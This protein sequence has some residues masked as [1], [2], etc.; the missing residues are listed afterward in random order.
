MKIL[1]AILALIVIAA[2]AV[3]S[4]RGQFP[5]SPPI[6]QQ[7]S[8]P[9]TE[10]FEPPTPFSSDSSLKF[11][12]MRERALT[13]YRLRPDRRVLLAV[14]EIR[15]LA[16]SRDSAVTAQFA[17]GRWTVRC[18][19]REIGR[20]SELPDFPE[21]LDMITEVARSQAWTRGWSDNGGPERADLERALDRL[22]ALAALREADR[23]WSAGARDAALFRHAALAYGLLALETP[24]WAGLEDPIAA[25]GLAALAYARALGAEDPKRETCLLADVTGYA[26]AAREQ[27]RRLK[28]SDPVRL[29]VMRDAAGLERLTIDAIGVAPPAQPSTRAAAT[30]KSGLSAKL[31]S[32]SGATAARSTR[33]T[34]ATK[35]RTASKAASAT[36]AAP[37]VSLEAPYFRLVLA[38][39]RDQD[40][41]WFGLVSRLERRGV[42]SSLLLGSGLGIQS[43]QASVRAAER[44]LGVMAPRQVTTRKGA[45]KP[46]SRAP[47][48]TLAQRVQRYEG[49]L[50]AKQ[51]PGGVLLSADIARAHRRCLVYAALDEIAQRAIET[52][53]PAE[54]ST[55]F[56]TGSLK[57]TAKTP[58]AF[59][60]WYAHLANARVGKLDRVGLRADI[61]SAAPGSAQ[62]I[63]SY[64][65]LRAHIAPEDPAVRDAARD[66]ARRLDS[67]PANRVALAAIAVRDLGALSVAERLGTS[68]AAVLASSDP[69]LLAWKHL[70]KHDG[71]SLRAFVGQPDLPDSVVGAS[72]ARKLA[73]H[74]AAWEMV[75]SYATWLEESGKY[76]AARRVLERWMARTQGDS[77][78]MAMS[79]DARIQTARL[80]QLEGRAQQA[81]QLMG[82]L[83]RSGNF[84]AMERTALILQDL[85]QPNQ[86]LAIGWAA[87]RAA[88]HL[89]AG[90]ALLAELFWRQG[91]YGE[92]A[93]VLQNARGRLSGV[94]WTREIAPRFVAFFRTRESEGVQAAEALMRAGFTDRWTFG[95]IPD[96]LGA[97]GL[98]GLAFE[99]QSRMQLSGAEGFE[100][101]I[102]AYRHLKHAKGEAMAIEWI[103]R[104]VPESDRDLLGIL[105]WQEGVPELLWTMA[106]SRLQ[107]ELGDYHW[108]LRAAVCME[109]GSAHPRYAETVNH[110]GRGRGSHHLEVA[111]YLLGLREESEVLAAT[112][113]LRQRS[114]VYYFAGLKAEQRGKLRD[115]ADWYF[116]SVESDT[117]NNIESRWALRRLKTWTDQARPRV[118][119]AG[120]APPA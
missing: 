26:A 114:E 119:A 88:P 86:A 31:R 59:Q 92:A 11:E 84:E 30:S 112:K 48:P 64:E 63:R 109:T 4:Y 10:T 108:L 77:A 47:E 68:A 52:K 39:D 72:L 79:L 16:G 5:S 36:T 24:D 69:S 107:G 70:F 113:T 71:D 117:G 12:V 33:G 51:Q 73:A 99:L 14:T 32:K 7:A 6:A 54:I 42:P 83:H 1:M 95:S 120:P 35:T 38:A 101:A 66:L 18:G 94:E 62:A 22:D 29:Y 34:T 58:A 80:L 65:A 20:L 40:E 44:L 49:I 8:A 67:R 37:P 89:A 100:S 60:R 87:H 78:A 103:R 104:R 97:E 98:H 116:M 74:P 115:A 76:P 28:A 2:V 50:A 41:A 111:R 85:G 57:K 106:P 45:P 46:A 19:T 90:P 105:A 21:M 61:D 9:V 91:R 17:G 75:E 15:R 13:P 23:A 82:D 3:V 43:G 81:L 56:A 93:S 110:I 96:A 118:A 25:R 53:S 55:W 27:A 102:V